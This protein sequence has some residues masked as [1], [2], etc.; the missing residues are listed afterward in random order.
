MSQSKTYKQ[1]PLHHQP[2]SLY[3][4]EILQA[5][6]NEKVVNVISHAFCDNESMTAY[7]DINE[8]TFKPFANLKGKAN[9]YLWVI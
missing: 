1:E 3:Q 6:H 5:Q 9:A 4:Y 2:A 8:E 7:L